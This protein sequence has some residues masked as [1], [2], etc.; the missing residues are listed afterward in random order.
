[1]A[2]YSTLYLKAQAPTTPTIAFTDGNVLT[3]QTN[4]NSIPLT[5]GKDSG[6]TDVTQMLVYG[7]KGATTKTF[8]GD[9]TTTTFTYESTASDI[10]EYTN[11][12][13][14]G[15]TSADA[16]DSGTTGTV[17]FTTAP[18][19]GDVIVVHYVKKVLGITD[20]SWEAFSTSKTIA[21][22]RTTVE[23]AGSVTVYVKIRDDVYNE[24]S[25]GSATAT[26]DTQAP[27]ITVISTV[28]GDGSYETNPNNKISKVEGRD[29][30][31]ITFQAS[32]AIVAWKALVVSSTS[33]AHDASGNIQIPETAG[34]TTHA[35][36]TSISADTDVACI[37]KG[38][39]L[40]TAVTNDGS[41]T[42]KI[43]GQDS[44]G[45]WSA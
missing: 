5:I 8:T 36:N 45:N 35:T 23:T 39:D 18:A 34:S 10:A 31:T 9:G 22:D 25:V 19:Q 13:V 3:A 40:Q 28:M 37:I 6:D 15:T 4:F 7:Y 44:T 26:V 32:E 30:I 27:S 24:S 20:A 16:S 41:Y 43:F 1:M 12:T 11:T 29:T 21:L 38:T 17:T 33:A 14:N 42:I 2:S